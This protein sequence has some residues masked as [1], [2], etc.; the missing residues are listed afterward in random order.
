MTVLFQQVVVGLVG[1][2]FLL[3][4]GLDLSLERF[5][6][7]PVSDIE[8]GKTAVRISEVSLG[9]G[10]EP[11]LTSCVPNLHLYYLIVY[12]KRLNLKIDANCT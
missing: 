6:T 1:A 3:D 4:I 11:F 8:D 7:L 2:V 9:N 5:P 10:L 12:F